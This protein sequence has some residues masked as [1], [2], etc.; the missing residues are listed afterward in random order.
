MKNLL[1]VSALIFQ[2]FAIAEQ[3]VSNPFAGIS[4][5]I[6]ARNQVVLK[7][8]IRVQVLKIT[9]PTDKSGTQNLNR[10]EGKTIFLSCFGSVQT[11]QL[12]MAYLETLKKGEVFPIDIKMEKN[13]S[14][15]INDLNP[16]QIETAK[17]SQIQKTR[18]MND[19]N[20]LNSRKSDI[21]EMQINLNRL[22]SENKDLRDRVHKLE[23][24]L[25]RLEIMI[26]SKN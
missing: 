22:R 6:M 9:S 7:S 1:L 14:W 20:L 11:R 26:R 16:S 15:I 24:R 8:G 19:Q 12:Q 2:T 3:K 5:N 25:S 21:D 13:G 17:I 10:L 4:L 23:G 18:K